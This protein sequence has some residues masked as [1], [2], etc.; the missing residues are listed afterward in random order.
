MWLNWKN[1]HL[2]YFFQKDAELYTKILNNNSFS[3]RFRRSFAKTLLKQLNII[4]SFCEECKIPSLEC[5]FC[6]NNSCNGGHGENCFDNCDLIY[7]IYENLKL[8]DFPIKVQIK[9]ILTSLGIKE[10]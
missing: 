3:K 5:P 6:G 7:A 10:S 4:V 8:R 2:V 9:Y 1:R